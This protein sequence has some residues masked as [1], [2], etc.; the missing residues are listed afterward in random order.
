MLRFPR[1]KNVLG[2]KNGGRKQPLEKSQMFELGAFFFTKKKIHPEQ[3]ALNQ[4]KS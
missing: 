2:K 4:S 1:K 3:M